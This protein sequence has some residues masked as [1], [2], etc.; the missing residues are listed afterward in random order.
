[1]LHLT[2]IS[3][4]LSVV[5]SEEKVTCV[6]LQVF[7]YVKTDPVTVGI[8]DEAQAHVGSGVVEV[9]DEIHCRPAAFGTQHGV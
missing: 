7:E 1:M 2:Y 5:K 8:G 4:H 9:T 6:Y 3:I